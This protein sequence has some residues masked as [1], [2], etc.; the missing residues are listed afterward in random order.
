MKETFD[1]NKIHRSRHDKIITGLAGGIAR[2]FE[3][4]AFWVRAAMIAGMFI[5]PMFCGMSYLIAS[6]I[7]KER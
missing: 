3:F 7:I 5:A 1:I 6:L 2:Q 4:E